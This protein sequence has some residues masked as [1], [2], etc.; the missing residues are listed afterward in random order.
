MFFKPCLT[1]FYIYKCLLLRPCWHTLV[2]PDL[3]GVRLLVMKGRC[4]LGGGHDKSHVILSKII[5]SGAGAVF[6]DLFAEF[7]AADFSK[8]IDDVF[9]R[10]V[11]KRFGTLVLA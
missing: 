11:H 10:G 6:S 4:P 8:Q 2:N 1:N 5:F 7:C 9:E 3:I